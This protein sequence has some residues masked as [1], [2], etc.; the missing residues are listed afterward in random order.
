MPGRKFSTSTS[1]RSH[2]PEEDV[3]VAG[4]LQVEGDAALVAAGQLPPQRHA[5]AGVAPAHAPHGV[6]GAGPLD[7]DHVGAEVGE[8]AG[9][10]RAG[11][12]GGE[13]DDP[14]VR[15][16]VR[17]R[18]SV[19]SRWCPARRQRCQPCSPTSGTKRTAPRRSLRVRPSALT[20]PDTDE[21]LLVRRADR[22][23]PGGRRRRAAATSAGGTFGAPA[24]T[25]MASNGA[26]SAHA[27][28]AVGGHDPD[29]VVAQL[30]QQF[31]GGGGQP[32]HALDGH[33]VAGQAR[34]DGGG[35][36]RSRRP[37]RARD[38]SACS[39]SAVDH[40]R[41]HVRLRD[42]LAGAGSGSG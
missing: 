34:Q 15:R 36:A 20:Q 37:P 40:E 17:A 30:A 42:G 33:H 13:V 16:A 4:V 6:A 18:R 27:G 22:A 29:V 26:S 19:T 24:D 14:Q 1:A 28:R 5:V 35:V 8:V 38:R 41:H 21:L 32:G 3:E 11:E 7:L 31:G 2:R 39:S 25:Q 12:H 10:R 9:A 23:R